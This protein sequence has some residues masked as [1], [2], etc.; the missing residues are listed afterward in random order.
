MGFARWAAGAPFVYN[1]SGPGRGVGVG[2]RGVGVGSPLPGGRG[3]GLLKKA[4][5]LGNSRAGFLP[6]ACVCVC[7]CVE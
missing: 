2:A 5:I 7:V 6:S 3:V 1:A 4:L